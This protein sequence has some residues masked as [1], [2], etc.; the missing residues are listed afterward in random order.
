MINEYNV[1]D[2]TYGSRYIAMNTDGEINADAQ[3]EVN[4]SAL[5]WDEENDDDTKENHTLKVKYHQEKLKNILELA[6]TSKQIES[7]L[8]G[9]IKNLKKYINKIKKRK[10]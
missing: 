4:G 10:L 2:G 9:E 7:Y 8:D 5:T 3:Q 1:E 6:S